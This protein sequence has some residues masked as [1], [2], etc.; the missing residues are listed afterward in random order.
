MFFYVTGPKRVS[1]LKL[2]KLNERLDWL[3]QWELTNKI[4][5]PFLSFFFKQAFEPAKKHVFMLNVS[6]NDIK[7]RRY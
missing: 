3:A 4:I 7:D 2:T 6:T 5:L 1:N